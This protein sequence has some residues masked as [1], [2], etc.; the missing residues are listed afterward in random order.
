MPKKSSI[1]SKVL[2]SLILILA[3]FLSYVAMQP[4]EYSVSREIFIAA[5]PEKIFPFL[6]NAKLGEKWAPWSKIDPQATMNYSGPEEGV[7]A[8][9]SWDSQGQ[10]GTGS[11]TITA[12]IP[13]HQ[14]DVALAYTKPME[15]NQK[16][17]YLLTPG[18][19]G[20]TVI[21]MVSGKQNFVGRIFCVFINMDKKVGGMFEMGLANLKAV[22]EHS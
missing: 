22:V 8:V 5:P 6:N 10:L 20:S 19:H 11:A 3:V 16:A 18:D 14:V 13:N 7:G 2:G 17:M 12:S 21:W 9:T 15:M 4:A 1:L